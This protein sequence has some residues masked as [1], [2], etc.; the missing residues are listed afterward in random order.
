MQYGFVIICRNIVFQWDLKL[1]GGYKPKVMTY[2]WDKLKRHS[3]DGLKPCL[4]KLK[5]K[6]S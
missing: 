2:M 6:K 4:S 5:Y 3:H 1:V